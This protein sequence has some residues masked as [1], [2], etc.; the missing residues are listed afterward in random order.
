[1]KN[2]VILGST[3]SIGVSAL[4]VIRNLPAGYR[5]LGL[6]ANRSWKLLL[7]QAEEFKPKFI[8]LS[9]EYAY[10]QA[11]KRLPK[12]IKLLPPDFESLLYLASHPKCDIVLNGL[13]GSIGLL[14]TLAAIRAGKTIALAN[15]EPM[16]M[17]GKL[18]MQECRRHK[19]KIIPVDSEPSAVFQ[20][21]NGENRKNIEKIILTA[22][23]GPFFEYKGDLSKVTTEQALSHPKWK[24]GLKVTIDSATLMNKG[25]ETIEIMNLFSLPVEKIET[26]IHPQSVIH[27]AVEYKDGSIIAQMSTPDMRLPIQYAL[28]YPK[29]IKSLAKPLNL[30]ELGKLEFYKPDPQKFPTLKLALHCAKKGG[31]YPAV[32][33]AASEICSRAFAFEE[34]KF[35]DIFKITEKVVKLYKGG[36]RNPEISEIIET[37]WW[38][39]SETL[40]LIKK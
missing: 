15:K 17:A 11:K 2:I 23:G 34:M 38:A 40:K 5:V 18:L 32:L 28:T 10:K 39:K 31:G 4:W 26:I 12:N 1:M 6:C 21:L 7:H 19:A 3:G 33:N 13:S 24:M 30:A 25:L 37:D 9:D 29:R 27:S 35:T 8:T 22:S 36:S 20:C 16:V 14:P